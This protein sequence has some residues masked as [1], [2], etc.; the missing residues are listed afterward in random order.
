[1]S[2]VTEVAIFRKIVEDPITLQLSDL[3][4]QSAATNQQ[5]QQDELDTKAMEGKQYLKLIHQVW[6]GTTK[7]IRQQ[8]QFQHRPVEY[9]GL[10]IFMPRVLNPEKVR[11]T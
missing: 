2:T 1:M 6:S 10:A 7:Y 11:L 8:C 5:A 3:T 9:P 4:L